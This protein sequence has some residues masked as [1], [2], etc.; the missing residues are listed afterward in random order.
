MDDSDRLPEEKPFLND[1][2]AQEYRERLQA[3]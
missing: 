2:E 1:M 3:V